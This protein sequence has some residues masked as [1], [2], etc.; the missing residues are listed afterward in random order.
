MSPPDEKP[1]TF[2]PNVIDCADQASDLAA[3]AGLWGEVMAAHAPATSASIALVERLKRDDA[4]ESITVRISYEIIR[5]FSEGLYQSPHKAIEELVT[6]SFDAGAT[7]TYVLTPRTGDAAPDKQDSLW[8]IDNGSGMDRAGFQSLW[9]VAGSDKYFAAGGPKGRLPIGQ[10][11]IGKLAAYVL[12]WRLTHVSKV[13]ATYLYTSMNFRDLIG[14]HQYEQQT[15]PFNISLHEITEPE[16]RG[17]LSEVAER[18][19]AAWA[20]LFGDS[21][22]NNWTAAALSDYKDLFG[23]LKAGTL[24]WVLRSGLPIATDFRIFLNTEEL[25]SPKGQAAVLAELPVGGPDDEQAAKLGLQIT[26]TG[27][28]IDGI[29]SEITGSARLFEAPLT[30][31]KSTQ[32]GRSH[33]YFI[34]VRRRVINLEDELFGIPALNHAAWSRF[35]LDMD[36]DGLRDHLLSSREGVRDSEPIYRLRE[37]LHL[38]FNACRAIYEQTVRDQLIGLDI[39]SL[40]SEAPSSLVADP[41]VDAVRTEASEEGQQLY[42]IQAPR[43]LDE[44]E[45]EDWLDEFESATRQQPF[46]ALQVE[47]LGAYDR[48]AEYD[49]NSRVLR[50]N[51]DHPFISKLA[52]HSKNKTPITMFA[53]AEVLTDA[54]LREYGVDSQTALEFFEIRDKALRLIAGDY[55]P[56]PAEVLR[57]LMIADQD[58]DALEKAVGDA[59]RVLG[60]D[61]ERRGGNRGGP[62]G[63]LDARL[64]R[65]DKE[66][67]D[68]RIV[69]DAKTTIGSSVPAD[70]VNF[71]ALWAFR[72]DEEADFAFV[73]GRRF[74]GQDDERSVLSKRT[75]QQVGNGQPVSV[76]LTEDLRR[77]VQLHYKHGVTLT[78]LRGLFESAHTVAQTRE[79]V[80]GLHSALSS[81]DVQVPVKRLLERLE[82]AKRDTKSRPNINAARAVDGRLKDFEPERLAAA[83]SAVQTIIG[84]RWIEVNRL[85]GDVRLHHTSDQILVE[86]QRRLKDELDLEVTP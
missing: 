33:G 52:A 76:I 53:T 63:V 3:T 59:F 11:G 37:Y 12:A 25:K 66:L 8:V 85:S 46:S 56:D 28:L 40:L 70:K 23:K 20:T 7:S 2:A 36:A 77:I 80:A 67:A 57:R 73:I 6:N 26:P 74:D 17:L 51:E 14:R 10:F 72:K 79:W 34:R 32:Y 78:Q 55:G 15:E 31:G 30:T 21:A 41:L 65:A 24:S 22:S 9:R 1:V 44:E 82:E 75:V 49:A 83:L 60:F 29:A 84:T 13:D 27:L 81:P 43:N 5:L 16:A 39:K 69:Y 35:V 86:V 38:K 4:G 68:Y 45:L 50:I 54:F 61:Y 19:P 48:L 42:Y 71:A 58:K 62:D 18:D 47:P 64:G